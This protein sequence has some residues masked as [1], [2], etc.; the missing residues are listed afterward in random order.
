[1][2][3][4][5]G[6]PRAQTWPA[7][8]AVA[9]AGPGV[10]P[11]PVKTWCHDAP[12]GECDRFGTTMALLCDPCGRRWWRPIPCTKAD[13]PRCYESVKNRRGARANTCLG[14][15]EVAAFTVTF[16][17]R[18]HRYIVGRD[19]IIEISKRVTEALQGW[20]QRHLG[21]VLGGRM[22]W[23][24][25]GDTCD[26]CGF[27]S[28]S[29]GVLGK[30]EICGREATYKPH[31]NYVIA[32]AV[33]RNDKTVAPRH[34]FLTRP[35]LAALKAAIAE[36][37]AEMAEILPKVGTGP[38][39]ANIFWEYR[40]ETAKKVHCFRYFLRHFPAWTGHVGSAKSFG[41][42]AGPSV[43][44]VAFRAAVRAAD[45]RD[46]VPAGCPHCHAKLAVEVLSRSA[47]DVARIVS[48]RWVA[49]T[50]EAAHSGA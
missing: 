4:G 1:M 37:M 8:R 44:A 34:L 15:R 21:G 16:P 6:R 20:S 27:S 25:C 32:G 22:N 11:R 29:L 19:I 48:S 35:Q 24:P 42:A 2:S 30:C 41:A 28:A 7:L 3:T 50:F 12:T 13:C 5:G 49:A 26:G 17:V 40:T 39:V 31:I 38:P 23:H 14:G 18:W 45:P 47:G 36:I 33:L 9:A 46:E 10:L 43:G